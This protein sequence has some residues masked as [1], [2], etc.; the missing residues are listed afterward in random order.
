[1]L[2]FLYVRGTSVDS[3]PYNFQL[4]RTTSSYRNHRTTSPIFVI[5]E[6]RFFSIFQ[7]F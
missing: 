2:I 7:P 3:V 5:L 4:D 1:L 6:K